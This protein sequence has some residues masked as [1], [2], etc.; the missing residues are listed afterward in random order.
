VNFSKYVTP[1]S[2]PDGGPELGNLG[3]QAEKR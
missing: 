1:R 3:G 2:Q